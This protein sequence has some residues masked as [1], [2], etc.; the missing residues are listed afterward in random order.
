MDNDDYDGNL[1]LSS[2]SDFADRRKRKLL[3]FERFDEESGEF[4][5]FGH[6]WFSLRNYN[7][8]LGI[9]HLILAIVFYIYFRSLDKTNNVD[10][11]N[12]SLYNHVFKF[13]ET[14]NIFEAMNEE[15]ADLGDNFVTTLIIN[16]FAITAGFHFFYAFDYG[17][18]YS[19][20]VESGNNYFRWI[21]Y[22]IT[23]TMMLVI[24]AILSG[25]KDVKNYVLLV[26]SGFAMIWTGQWFETSKGKMKWLPI[27]IGFVLLMG[28]FGV[29]WSSFSERLKEVKAAGFELPTWLWLT[30]I[31]LFVFY[32]SFG[33]AP[34]ANKIW[35]GKYKKYE[36]AYLTLSLFSK[37]SLGSFIAYG[38]G[39][40][41]ESEN[42]S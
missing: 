25:V 26:T 14:E 23:A 19:K 6:E 13:N 18:L 22:S 7:L 39:Q 41:R 8:V 34:I 12:L 35:G 3:T 4:K 32:A 31:I 42:A 38:F 40:R 29:I 10:G 37:A 30:V 24:I 33:F 21:E 1:R 16:F 2:S 20:A 27:I 5:S 9:L 17:G 28:A 11:I 15:F 36:T